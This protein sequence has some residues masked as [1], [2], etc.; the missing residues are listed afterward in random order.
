MHRRKVP[1]VDLDSLATPAVAPQSTAGQRA[2]QQT[3]RRQSVTKR[4]ATAGTDAARPN[5]GSKHDSA[6]CYHEKLAVVV[7]SFKHPNTRK[8]WCFRAHIRSLT[9]LQ[10]SS[11]VCLR[12][13]RLLLSS[14]MTCTGF[15]LLLCA[16]T[17]KPARLRKS[18]SR[19]GVLFE[20][21]IC[22]THEPTRC[23]AVIHTD[24]IYRVTFRQAGYFVKDSVNLEGKTASRQPICGQSLAIG[25]QTVRDM[26]RWQRRPRSS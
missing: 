1:L 20:A 23:S 11:G 26:E 25:G 15:S 3:P 14:S 18:T 13:R 4:R 7:A 16:P 2:V 12:S 19:Y 24:T 6:Q 9:I 5:A 21:M 10:R 17:R 22:G 8:F